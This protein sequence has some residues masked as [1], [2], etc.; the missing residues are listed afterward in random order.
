MVNVALNS[1][2]TGTADFDLSKYY[3]AIAVA[4]AAVL[5]G[6]LYYYMNNAGNGNKKKIQNQNSIIDF[7]NQSRE[8]K[9]GRNDFNDF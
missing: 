9:V 7:K 4:G 5:G 1:S 3:G 2:P 6:A 8:V